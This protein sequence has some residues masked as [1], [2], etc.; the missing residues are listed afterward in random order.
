VGGWVDPS[1]PRAIFAYAWQSWELQ[2]DATE[3]KSRDDRP[4]LPPASLVYPN[5]ITA[6][7]AQSE[8]AADA[9]PEADTS[10]LPR[11]HGLLRSFAFAFAGLAFHFRSQR[12]ARIE[13]AVGILACILG[14]WLGISSTQWAVIVLT[15][16]LVL[17]LEGLNTS[18]EAA[19]DLFSPRLHPLAK[20]AKDLA[21]GMVLIAS[22]A[23]VVVGIL[24]LGP[25]LWHRLP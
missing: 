9:K 24:I 3:T 14:L 7:D 19:I 13:L 1:Y 22:L 6:A 21:A 4:V 2:V 18:I 20:S 10:G 17:I 8:D 25:P 15:I 23:A 11:V 16:A 5:S 12:N